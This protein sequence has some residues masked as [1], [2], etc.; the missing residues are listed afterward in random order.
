MEETVPSWLI[1]DRVYDVL[2]W[3]GLVVFPALAVCFGTVA[4][5]C[6]LDAGISNTVVLALNAV[7]T[8]IGVV[9][10]A[11]AIKGTEIIGFE[12]AKGGDDDAEDRKAA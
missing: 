11:S 1:P 8:F 12:E 5:A 7:G 9:I 10:G 4:P 2:K 6:G 3:I